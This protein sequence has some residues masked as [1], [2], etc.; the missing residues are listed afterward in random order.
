MVPFISGLGHVP[1]PR[2]FPARRSLFLPVAA[3]FPTFVVVASLVARV[4]LFFSPFFCACPLERGDCLPPEFRSL[5]YV[6]SR[7]P[8]FITNQTLPS[9]PSEEIFSPCPHCLCF[10]TCP[11]RNSRFH[12]SFCLLVFCVP[13]SFPFFLPYSPR[14]PLE[15][16]L[17]FPFSFAIFRQRFQI[18][19]RLRRS[20][21]S[22]FVWVDVL[23][24]LL[25]VRR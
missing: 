7:V 19:G 22:L 17:S 23:L 5:R 3:S 18:G 15:N 13:P 25:L 1:Y 4:F 14:E 20:R 11:S 2:L 10:V 6:L 16:H 24:F 9:T 8:T 12:S 21:C